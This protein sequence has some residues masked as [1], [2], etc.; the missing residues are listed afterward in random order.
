M[1][2]IARHLPAWLLQHLS[3]K[4][5]RKWVHDSASAALPSS[6]APRQLLVDVSVIHLGDART[7]IQ[8]VVR[9]TYQQLLATPPAGY[10]VCPIAATRKDGYHYLPTHFLEERSPN[11]TTGLSADLVQVGPGDLFLGLDLA[12]HIIPHR[13]SELWGWKEQGVRLYFYMYDLLPVLEPKW[14]NPSTT[15]NFKRW[16]RALAILADEIICISHTVEKEFSVWMQRTYGLSTSSIRCSVVPLGVD[17]SGF[18]SNEQAHVG[19]AQQSSAWLENK[20]VLMVGTIEPR[21]GHDEILNAFE[22]LWA[23]GETVNLVIAGKQGWKMKPFIHRLKNHPESDERLRWLE[24]P[25]D[26]VLL[27]LYQNASGLIMASKGEGFGLPLIEAAF[28]SKPVFARDIPIFREVAI[29]NVTFFPNESSDHIFD[30]LSK[31]VGG[32][33]DCQP[34]IEVERKNF[35]TWQESNYKLVRLITTNAL[36]LRERVI[37][38]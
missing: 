26:E 38:K 24:G 16:L 37:S 35:V 32:L 31:W 18:T 20:F 15:K 27:Q 29:G 19:V 28:F 12:A 21:K 17:I 10:R 1:M 11:F 14:F 13:M 8:R 9:N 23:A 5:F 22:E 6:A 25:S 7:G 4:L 36:R 30:A 34:G 3:V 2:K 33:T